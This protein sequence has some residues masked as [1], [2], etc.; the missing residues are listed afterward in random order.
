MKVVYQLT[1]RQQ[2][3][4]LALASAISSVAVFG[5][6]PS[7]T[8]AATFT[9]TNTNDSGS[10]SLR[11][12]I[13]SANSI[14]GG[15]HR[16]AFNIPTSDA[17][18]NGSVFT[19]QPTSS[20]PTLTRDGTIIDGASQTAVGN[21][22]SAGPEIVLDGTRVGGDGL[23]LTAANCTVKGLV[24]NGFS[25][26]GIFIDGAAATNN[27]VQ[28]CY[29]GIGAD[30]AAPPSS[31][32]GSGVVISGGASTNLIGGTTAPDRNVISGNTNVGIQIQQSGTNNNLVQGCYIG[33][34]ATARFSVGNGGSG[35]GII[36]G[37]QNNVI[38]GTTA[39]A[40]NIIS[41]NR[42]AGIQLQDSGTNLNRVQ[43][44]F[45]GADVT[46]VA[47]LGNS[48]GVIITFGASYNTVGG[49]VAA[50]RNIISANSGDGILIGGA[51][52][53]SSSSDSFNTQGNSV[54]GNYIGTN[55]AGT[56]NLGNGGNGVSVATGFH[57]W[58]SGG[59]YAIDNVVDSSI[60]GVGA[61][62]NRIAFNGQNGVSVAATTIFASYYDYPYPSGTTIRNTIFSNMAL[63]IDLQRDGS[64][65][66]SSIGAPVITSVTSSS[67]STTV[68]FTLDSTP[69]RSFSV[70]FYRNA[71]ADPSGYG[72]GEVYL[73]NATVTT[74]TSGH[75]ESTFVA[76][77]SFPGQFFGAVA[78]DTTTQET[79][80][81]GPV[82]QAQAAPTLA[83]NDVRV[84][85]PI[86]GTR[87]VNFT[88]TL[89]RVSD[90]T[91]TVNFASADGATNPATAG[92]DYVAKSGTLTFN[93]GITTRSITITINSDA[94]D[95]TNETFTVSL[96]R[97]IN[98]TL[99]DSRGVGT[100]INTP[101]DRTPPVS[102]AITTPANGAV[103]TSLPALSGTAQDNAGGSGIGQV[104]LRLLR[105]DGK[106][107]NAAALTWNTTPSDIAAVVSGT[108]WT[109]TA[110]LPSGAN[111]PNGVY[112]L[113]A[114]AIDKT[115]NVGLAG[116]ALSTF[117]V[118][119]ASAGSAVAPSAI[120]V[121]DAATE[122]A[123]LKSAVEISSGSAQVS[124][125][126]VQLT[127]GGAL[128]VANAA[129][130]GHYAIEVN[131]TTVGVERASYD[132]GVDTLTLHLPAG[133]L[134]PG[135]QVAVSWHGLLDEKGHSLSGH[136]GPLTAE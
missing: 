26:V 42:G 25:N 71:N 89:S 111:L 51:I 98:S 116:I 45:I 84:T 61:T 24:I 132:S 55:N 54:K 87:T 69:S 70:D 41:G 19:I 77:G 130:P 109:R 31:R 133:T 108:N 7:R 29:I 131:H 124:T 94:L 58:A 93:P 43:G 126:N 35:V 3:L 107:W 75:A 88:V 125:Q 34:D 22:N 21:T 13:T 63:G 62:A 100:I 44:N 95:E 28:G 4:K 23:V 6:A 10:G 76:A 48:T 50:A 117:T 8:L 96:S 123:A 119:V 30:G 122:R 40:R 37:A 135:D 91:V 2:F 14:A 46:G 64:S 136:A 68:N 128:D 65:G 78:T 27:L 79:S 110:R 60:G 120:A 127:F 113:Q 32:N 102:A 16:I 38:G 49:A 103:V 80:E 17:N 33:T 121:E 12:A 106:F 59:F 105:F 99:A 92:S 66:V 85:E 104:L 118:N 20:L 129:D 86:N 82:T 67:T 72:E 97:A 81:F 9:V 101:A 74:D 56:G 11:A 57:Q 15:P 18:F 90:H 112:S 134:R 115:N 53:S 1:T 114:V 52:L 36:S 39:S 73:G 83:I 5:F 47:G